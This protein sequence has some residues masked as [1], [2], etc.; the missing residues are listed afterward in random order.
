VEHLVLFRNSSSY[1][2]I[3]IVYDII[4]DIENAPIPGFLPPS[5]SKKTLRYISTIFIDM[6]DIQFRGSLYPRY[7][8]DIDVLFRYRVRCRIAISGY[9]DIEGKNFDVVHDI[10]AMSGFKEIEGFS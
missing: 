1:I 3:E 5:I 4:Y 8:F 6:Y 7:V 10:G 9:K 2:C